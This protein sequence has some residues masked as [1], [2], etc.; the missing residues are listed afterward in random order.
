M[1]KYGAVNVSKIVT[2]ERF[3][4]SIAIRCVGRVYNYPDSEVEKIVR[5]IPM[6]ES[7]RMENYYLTCI[8]KHTEWTD[9][10]WENEKWRSNFYKLK[11]MYKNDE[12]VR[13]ILDMAV[14]IMGMPTKSA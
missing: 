7:P 14:K 1:K 3:S 4:A 2:F 10:A 11:D 13:T 5:L 12:K 9:E 8:L 6:L